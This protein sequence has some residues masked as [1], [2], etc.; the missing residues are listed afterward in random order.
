MIPAASIIVPACDAHTRIVRAVRSA[1]DQSVRDIETIVV[2]DDDFD[3]AAFLAAQGIDDP[4]L[5]FTTTGGVRTGCHN[6]R[7]AGYAVARGGFVADLD[8]DDVWYP[9]RVERLLP[10]AKKHGAA[11]DNIAV[12]SDASGD[13]LYRPFNHLN[14]NLKLDVAALLALTCPLFPLVRRDMARPRTFGIEYAEDVVANLQLIGRTGAIAIVNETLSEYRVVTGSLSHDDRS[15]ERFETSYTRII[16]RLAD[17]GLDVPE[18][19][20]ATA[21]E[22]FARKRVLNRTLAEAQRAEPSLDFQTFVTRTRNL[23]PRL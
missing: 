20:R 5:S 14:Q 22:G 18:T 9:A 8:A 11:V 12:V 3:Y 15:A 7:N 6:A 17:D 10:E 13:I 1:L 4:R 21:I 16:E 19:L 23:S 2:A